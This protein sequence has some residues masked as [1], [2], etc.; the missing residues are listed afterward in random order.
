MEMSWLV[1]AQITSSTDSQHSGSRS[2]SSRWEHERTFSVGED[3]E[4]TQPSFIAGGG[5]KWCSHCVKQSGGP[6]ESKV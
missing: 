3:G 1:R 5:V 4:K 2:L 6:S